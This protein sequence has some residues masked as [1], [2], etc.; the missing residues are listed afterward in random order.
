[1]H[2]SPGR[3]IARITL[4]VLFIGILIAA[5][6]WVLRPFRG[7]MVWATMI[8]VATWPMMLATEARL[9]GRRWAAVVLMTASML[10]LLGWIDK[11]ETRQIPAAAFLFG[12]AVFAKGLVP[13]VLAVP[14]LC[15]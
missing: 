6:L 2:R 7:A 11:G 8:V 4:S 1:M 9:G 3:D 10:L 15:D 5:C 13:L 12:L 14:L